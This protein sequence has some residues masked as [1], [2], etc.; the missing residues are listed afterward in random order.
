[1]SINMVMGWIGFLG[2]LGAVRFAD[3]D[4]TLQKIAWDVL[5][6]EGRI[7]AGTVEGSGDQAVLR[8]TSE[9]AGPSTFEVVTIDRPKVSRPRYALQGYSPPLRRKGNGRCGNA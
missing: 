8:I 9:K 5:K 3:A 4:E 2:L 6:K 7:A 1:M